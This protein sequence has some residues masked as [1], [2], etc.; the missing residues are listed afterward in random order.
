LAKRDLDD[1]ALTNEMTS[2]DVPQFLADFAR[3]VNGYSQCAVGLA[4]ARQ[5]LR[6]R[7][8]STIRPHH[9]SPSSMKEI[10]LHNPGIHKKKWPAWPLARLFFV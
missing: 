2:G 8:L 1:G 3:E 4:D 5:K 7:P 10:I 9:T 6:C